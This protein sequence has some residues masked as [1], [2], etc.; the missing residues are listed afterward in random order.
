VA[1]TPYPFH[2]K[3][4]IDLAGEPSLVA[5]IKRP[6]RTDLTLRVSIDVSEELGAITGTVEDTANPSLQIRVL[7]WRTVWNA[8]TYPATALAASYTALL[9]PQPAADAPTPTP[10]GNGY[11]TFSISKLGVVT[12]K[13]KLP[14]GEGRTG[15]SV[16]WPTGE[17]PLYA[18]LLTKTGTAFG[19]AAIDD[20]HLVTGR[21]NW[22]RL[23]QP[24]STLYPA[25]FVNLGC[26][27]QGGEYTPPKA[28]SM[29]FGLPDQAGNAVLEFSGGGIESAAQFASL[30]QTLRITAANL[31]LTAPAAQNPAGVFLKLDV[32]NGT[33]SGGFTLTDPGQSAPRVVTFDGALSPDGDLL[34]GGYFLLPQLPAGSGTPSVQSGAVELALPV[35]P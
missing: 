10:A 26:A 14:T 9:T 22:T 8:K 12:W 30:A 35:V 2:G 7:G 29:L 1:A 27:I 3:L 32:K 19:I 28:G 23:P 4:A 25:G 21:L 16:L 11:L 33:F 34:G 15:S 6:K 31:A 18:A 5:T 24:A 13:G 20:T 17:F